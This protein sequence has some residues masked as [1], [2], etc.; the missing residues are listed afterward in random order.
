MTIAA[1]RAPPALTAPFLVVDDFLPRDMA[2]AMRRDIEAHFADT[3]NHKPQTHQIWNYWHVPAMYTYLRTNPEKLIA[4]DKLNV[5][6]NA[7]KGFAIERLGMPDVSRP[8]LSLYVNGCKQNLHNDS[9]NGRFAYVYSLTKDQRLTTG[10]ETIVY[11]EGDLFRD[12]VGNAN[13]G[14]GFFS[15]IEPRFN[16]LVLFDDRMPHA[17]ERVDGSMDPLEGRFVFHGHIKEAGAMVMGALKPEVASEVVM[18][19][20]APF[21]DESFARIRL[22]HG[23]LV[24]RLFVRKDGSVEDCAVVLDRVTAPDRGDAEWPH[25]RMRLM[26]AFA[27]LKFP[28]AA[29]DTVITQ[30]VTFGG[31]LFR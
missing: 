8:Y 20:L 21:V 4:I 5:F 10:G 14:S 28:E 30:P 18:S 31:A 11:K 9:T 25:L 6:F 13:A 12:N 2:L 26:K 27:A 24:L 16:R 3:Q 22:Y 19:A 7:L 1:T 15:A 23:P 17:V 29:G